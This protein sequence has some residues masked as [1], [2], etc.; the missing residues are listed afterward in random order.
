MN[1]EVNIREF[2]D[3]TALVMLKLKHK[4]AGRKNMAY[5]CSFTGHRSIKAEHEQRLPALIDKAVEYAYSEGCREFLA[6]GAVGFDTL[7]AR[8]VVR[9]RL[10]HPDVRLMLVLPCTN[11]DEKWRDSQ[12]GAYEYLLSVAD[13][14]EYISEEYTENCMRERNFRLANRADIVIAYVGRNR[15]GAAQTARMAD[16]M[17]KTVYNLYKFLDQ[18]ERN[19]ENA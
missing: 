19:Q 11:Q 9:F 14:V 8:S 12:R 1:I 16:S 18:G 7:A 13:E 10:S 4:N 15:S 17:G 6:G 2:I 5:Y 3:K